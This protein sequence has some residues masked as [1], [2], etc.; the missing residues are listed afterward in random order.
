[1]KKI[2]LALLISV[3]LTASSAELQHGFSSPSFSGIGYSTHILTIKQL[4]DQ[5]KQTNKNIADSLKAQA[6]RDAATDPQAQ[7]VAN[8]QARIYS[9]LAKQLTDSLF[10]TAGTPACTSATAGAICGEIPDIAGN[11][12]TWKL[13]VGSDTGMIIIT[14]QNLTD[15]TQITTMKVPSGTFAF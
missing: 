13:G 9:Q 3:A 7:F 15:A 10:G 1:M 12:I 8:L 5:G 4:E 11:N 2:T 6:E 14:I